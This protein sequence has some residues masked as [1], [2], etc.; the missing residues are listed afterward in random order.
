MSNDGK[1]DPS[2]IF[3]RIV[4][5]EAPA[6]RV[7]EDEATLVFLDIF[8]V[9][10]GHTLIITKGHHENLFEAPAGSLA[11]VGAVS[12]RIAEALREELAPAGMMVFQ[13]NGADAGQTVFHYHMHLLPRWPGQ[14]LV[15]HTRVPGDPVALAD[16][17]AKLVARLERS[18]S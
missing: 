16:L 6:H 2:C 11:A 3:C 14:E 9:S 4:A 7:W 15:L 10:P 18:A 5:G 1:H 8:P 17:A 12:K 13:L